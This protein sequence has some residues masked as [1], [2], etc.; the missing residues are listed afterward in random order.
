MTKMMKILF[1]I[2]QFWTISGTR[3]CSENGN[4]CL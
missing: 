1:F 2:I 3:R 4:R